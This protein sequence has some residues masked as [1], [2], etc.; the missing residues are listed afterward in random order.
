MIETEAQIRDRVRRA[1]AHYGSNLSTLNGLLMIERDYA[2]KTPTDEDV[3]VL[4]SGGLDSSVLVQKVIG[5]FNVKVHP[6]FIKRGSR[7]QEFEEQ[8][9]DFFA[10]FYK[11]RFPNNFFEPKK[12]NYEV[13]PNELK[14]DFPPA[15]AKT[16]GH[17]LRNSTM[18]NLAVMYAVSLQTKGVEAKTIFAGSVY[19][20]NTE[21]ELGLLSL[22]AQTVATCIEMGDWRWNITSPLTDPY[23]TNACVSKVDLIKYAFDTFVPIERTRTCF[24]SEPEACGTCNACQTRIAA[25]EEAGLPDNITYRRIV[26]EK[27]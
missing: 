9:F 23:L 27:I 24:G 13:P 12:L 10:D 11:K 7:N 17:P 5:E 21:P 20:D 4:M 6:L 18:Q 16:I 22:R 25:F 19:E 26:N 8:A 2:S 3:V 1:Q 14:A 15:L